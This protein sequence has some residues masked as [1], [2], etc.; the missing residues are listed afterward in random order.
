MKKIIL[1]IAL[2]MVVGMTNAQ[3]VKTKSVTKIEKKA[4]NA[5]T[6]A[7]PVAEEKACGKEGHCK[8]GHCKEGHCMKE[9][10]QMKDCCKDKSVKKISKATKKAVKADVKGMKAAVKANAKQQKS[11]LKVQKTNA[12]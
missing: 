6:T 5:K 12:K 11:V 4:V 8:E 2:A 3:S 7:T 9:A 1:S 10:G